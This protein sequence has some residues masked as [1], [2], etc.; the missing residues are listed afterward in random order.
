MTASADDQC[1]TTRIVSDPPVK[2]STDQDRWIVRGTGR[3]AANLRPAEIPWRSPAS[4]GGLS[5][6]QVVAKQERWAR[7]PVE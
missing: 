5:E 4:R 1:C 2:L 7:Y 6:W 3:P